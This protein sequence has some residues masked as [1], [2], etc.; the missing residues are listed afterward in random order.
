[1]KV[2]EAQDE[3]ITQEK[4][5]AKLRKRGQVQLSLGAYSADILTNLSGC[6]ETPTDCASTAPSTSKGEKRVRKT[7]EVFMVVFIAVVTFRKS[8]LIRL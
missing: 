8:C 6:S 5:V 7:M 3:I 1:M 4:I 2:E